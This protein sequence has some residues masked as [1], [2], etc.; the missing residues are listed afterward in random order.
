V[1]IGRDG[2]E[3]A[4]G[5]DKESLNRSMK[6]I[7]P[8]M[9]PNTVFKKWKRN[10]LTFPSLKAAYLIPHLASRES[11][12]RLDEAV[13]T[14]ANAMVLHDASENIRADQ[15]AKGIY[16]A[17]LDCANAAWDI[18]CERLYGRSFTRPFRF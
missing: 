1:V 2:H 8:T 15:A 6:M 9:G 4:T 11:G 16:D 18:L 3:A 7:V 10:F 5:F 12:V 13:Q 14:Y 17:R